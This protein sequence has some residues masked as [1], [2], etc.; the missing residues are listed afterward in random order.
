MS[1]I[2]AIIFDMDG[3]LID[4]KEWHYH[5][6]NKALSDFGY[7]IITREQHLT[8]FDGLPTKKKLSALYDIHQKPDPAMH[9]RITFLKQIYT[10]EHAKTACKPLDI[11]QETLS[12]LQRDGCRMVCCSNSVRNTVRLLL[13]LADLHQ[14]LEFFLSN[15]D[16]AKAKPDPEIY[17]KALNKL[18]LS[19]QEVLICEDNPYGLEA[20][21]A[22]GAHVLKID[23]VF[24]VNYPNIKNKIAA[25]ENDR[26]KLWIPEKQNAKDSVYAA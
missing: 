13:K 26:I 2:K 12:Q 1:K 15:Q 14:Y 6:L 22:S 7:P 23:T 24:D 4:A 11:H 9:T 20:A 21:G 25:I 10:I 3:V 19:P 8:V 5:A 16:V 18:E 17:L